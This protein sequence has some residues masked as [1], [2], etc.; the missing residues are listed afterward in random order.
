MDSKELLLTSLDNL[1]Y[2][3]KKVDTVLIQV[4]AML[5]DGDIEEAKQMLRIITRS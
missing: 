3:I 5:D 4:I 2:E 1:E